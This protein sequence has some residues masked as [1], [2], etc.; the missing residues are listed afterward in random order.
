MLGSARISTPF[1]KSLVQPFG[2]RHRHKPGAGRK[3]TGARQIFAAI[4]Y[5]LRS[6]CQWKA[7]PR[8]FGASSAIHAHFQRWQ[9]AGFFLKLWQAE[10]AEYDEMEGIASRWQSIEGAMEKAPV[11]CTVLRKPANCLRITGGRAVMKGSL[12]GAIQASTKTRRWFIGKHGA[13]L[14]GGV[15]RKRPCWLW[16]VNRVVQGAGYFARSALFA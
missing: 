14:V 10:L 15:V 13:R 9:R 3:P 4:V 6:G 8:E 12:R 5:V 7:L 2:N 16:S 11:R 1:P